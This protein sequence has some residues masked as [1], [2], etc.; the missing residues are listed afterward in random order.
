MTVAELI[1]LLE[2]MP[3]RS[4]VILCGSEWDLAVKGV[5]PRQMRPSRLP[6]QKQRG[7]PEAVVCLMPDT[8]GS[9]WGE[10]L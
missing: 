4:R 7:A 9:A 5:E 3:G 6:Y 10:T 8:D 2:T 1:A